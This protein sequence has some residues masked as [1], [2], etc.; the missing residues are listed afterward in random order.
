MAFQTM[1]SRSPGR[2][3]SPHPPPAPRKSRRI[4]QPR[5]TREEREAMRRLRE[6][7]AAQWVDAVKK[8]RTPSVRAH[9][10]AVVLFEFLYDHDEPW[11]KNRGP[12]DE[13]ASHWTPETC[14]KPAVLARAL[15]KVGYPPRFAEARAW[16][17][18]E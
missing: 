9:I 7:N 8:I 13:W 18:E 14:P 6:R 16:I 3:R 10:S 17:G 2:V 15:I 1:A 4:R 11:M 5:L 12:L